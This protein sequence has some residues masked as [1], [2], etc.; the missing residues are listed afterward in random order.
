MADIKIRYANN[1]IEAIWH[2]LGSNNRFYRAAGILLLR[3]HVQVLVAHG[4]GAQA[5]E[6]VRIF[7]DE[8][9]RKKYRPP[10]ME[11]RLVP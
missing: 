1:G 2:L 11:N 9:P 4:K 5:S 3:E 10:G 8:D 7:R 6:L